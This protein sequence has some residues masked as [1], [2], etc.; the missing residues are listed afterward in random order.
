MNKRYIQKKKN[1]M[2]KMK[3]EDSKIFKMILV[4]ENNYFLHLWKEIRDHYKVR[5]NYYKI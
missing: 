1:L 4:E 5:N 3:R 2:L